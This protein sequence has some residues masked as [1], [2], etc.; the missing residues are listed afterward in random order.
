VIDPDAAAFADAYL[1]DPT[2][3][4][5]LDHHAARMTAG[6]EEGGTSAVEMTRESYQFWAVGGVRHIADCPFFGHPFHFHIWRRQ[7]AASIA[8][9]LAVAAAHP[10][11]DWRQFQE[12]IW[13][14]RLDDTLRAS[15]AYA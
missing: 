5:T 6:A 7:D 10:A 12:L 3:D 14:G 1:A 13:S 2:D 9:D 15:V 8:S 4:D 11:P